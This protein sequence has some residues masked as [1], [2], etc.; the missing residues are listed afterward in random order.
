[1]FSLNKEDRKIKKIINKESKKR[2]QVI[3]SNKKLKIKL[4][5]EDLL[6]LKEKIIKYH[7]SDEVAI[8]ALARLKKEARSQF[9][10]VVEKYYVQNNLEL[11]SRSLQTL[12]AALGNEQLKER[13][14]N[15]YVVK[16]SDCHNTVD[17]LSAL[18]ANASPIYLSEELGEKLTH[19]SENGQYSVFIHRPGEFM[20]V[21]GFMDQVFMEGMISNGDSLMVGGNF[22]ARGRLDKTFTEASTPPTLIHYI[23]DACATPYKAMKSYNYGVFI[24]KIPLSVLENGDPIFYEKEGSMYLHPRYIDGFVNF[25]GDRIVSYTKNKYI[26]PDI[27]PTISDTSSIHYRGKS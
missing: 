20:L 17:V 24:A 14:D 2:N 25:D 23:K 9:D 21:D 18:V 1:M 10:A 4:D 19:L 15:G 12:C 11:D 27:E 5:K 26:V 16:A 7:I 22:S 13:N 6:Y 3:Q 8:F